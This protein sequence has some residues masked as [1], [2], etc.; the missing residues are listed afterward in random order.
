[1]TNSEKGGTRRGSGYGE[2]KMGKSFVGG[3]KSSPGCHPPLI[4]GA[5]LKVQGSRLGK[6][7]VETKRRSSV[8]EEQREVKKTPDVI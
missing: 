1:V 8:M 7:R 3:G 2:G 5:L 6:K 4:K